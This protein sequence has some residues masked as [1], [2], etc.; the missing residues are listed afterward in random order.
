[1]ATPIRSRGVLVA[2][3]ETAAAVCETS[4]A[5]FERF[6]MLAPAGSLKMP[7]LRSAFIALSRN[8]LLRRFGERSSVGVK[9]SS[10][11]VA[12]MEIDDALR[13]AEA[14][15]RQGMSVSLDSLGESVTSE[16]EAAHGSRSLSSPARCHRRAQAERQR[17]R[18]ADPDGP[19]AVAR[20]GGGH[21]RKPGAACPLAGQLC[22]HRHGGLVAHPGHARH[23]AAACMRARVCAAP[24]AS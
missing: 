4:V 19:R 2:H 8:R 20:N 3:G 24:S 6:T 16:A 1:M 15:N 23:R 5:G 14:V 22:P 21:R 12:G 10:R 17:Q 9:L 7:L 11:F 18:E 13:V